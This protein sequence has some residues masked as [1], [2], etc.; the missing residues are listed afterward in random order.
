ME[1]CIVG[2]GHVGLVTGA[3]LAEIGHRAVCV[4]DD[5]QKV[6]GLLAGQMPFFEPHLETLV[7]QNHARKRLLF[8][9]SL[10]GGIEQADIIFICVGTPSLSNGEADLSAVEQVARRIAETVRTEKLVVEKS[11]VPVQTARWVE[12]TLAMYNGGGSKCEVASNPEFLREG[13]AVEDFMHP[14][15]IVIGVAGD[16]GEKLLR[17]VYAP[18]T[19]GAF[20]C[21]IHHPCTNDQSVPL[22]VTDIQSAELIKH[23]SNAFLS[24]KI[25]F[26]NALADLCERAGADVTAVAEGL[27]LDR[28]IGRSFLNAGIGFG[29]YCFPKDLQALVNIAEKLGCNFALLREVERVNQSRAAVVLRKLKDRIWLLR[30][31]RIGVWGLAFKPNTDDVREAPAFRII[32]GLLQEGAEVQV[33]DPKAMDSARPKLTGVTFCEDPYQAAAGAEALVLATEWEEFKAVDLSKVKALMTWPLLL[34]GRN[35][36]D[37]EAMQEVGFEYIGMG[38]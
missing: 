17:E 11:T 16:R 8:T 25:S 1:L 3:C 31:K 19:D 29:G 9:E 34:D 18:I 12:R 24:M 10:E 6:A 27:G 32:D 13:S 30:G 35:F 4:D 36:F 2:A 28:R 26:I 33:Y 23:A 38:R 15:R 5:R 20:S 37:K 7:R 21:P 22:L 14:D